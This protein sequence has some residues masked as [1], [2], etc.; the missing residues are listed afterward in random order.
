MKRYCINLNSRPDRWEESEKEFEKLGWEVERFGVDTYFNLSQYNCLKEAVNNESSLILEDDCEFQNSEIMDE[1]FKV[2]PDDWD[3]LFLGATLNSVHKEKVN[4]YWYR[5]KNGW[6]TQAVVYKKETIKWILE[7]FNPKG[8]LIYDE[9]LRLNVLP[10]FNV[11]IIYPMVCF[12]RPSFS[13]I[14]GRFV[15][16]TN[17]FKQG[18]KLFI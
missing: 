11:Y 6:A 1:A 14:R 12:Q 18:E 13:D 15:D 7:H 10:K 8:G 5:Y 17:G 4:D 2:M 16:Y 3:V 9:W